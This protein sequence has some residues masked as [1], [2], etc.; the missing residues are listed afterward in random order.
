MLAASLSHPNFRFIVAIVSDCR[1]SLF[2]M[3]SRAYE[4]RFVSLTAPSVIVMS[5]VQTPVETTLEKQ[6]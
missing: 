6:H 2:W 1:I 4:E 5:L 3:S